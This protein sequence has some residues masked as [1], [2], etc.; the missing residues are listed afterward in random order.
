MSIGT[1]NHAN[2]TCTVHLIALLAGREHEIHF[3]YINPDKVWPVRNE[4]VRYAYEELTRR[5]FER[6]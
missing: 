6:R 3:T 5:Q 4:A 1:T 2:G